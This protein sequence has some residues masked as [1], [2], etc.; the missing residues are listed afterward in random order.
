MKR[1][2]S[3]LFFA[4][5]LALVGS[6]LM[7]ANHSATLHWTA[8]S[9]SDAAYNVYRCEGT[10]STFSAFSKLNSAAA[11]VTSY[12]DSTVTAGKSYSYA[13]TSVCPSAGCADGTAGESG[14][15]NFASGTIP[16]DTPAA[17][18]GCTVSVQ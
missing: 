6:S 1:A 16:K 17:P 3:I 14:P 7:A 11:G 15:S 10:C 8:V 5:M 2:I 4:L 12:T 13:V 9:E 18:T